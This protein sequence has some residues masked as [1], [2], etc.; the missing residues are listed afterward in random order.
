MDEPAIV[1]YGYQYIGQNSV[2][3]YRGVFIRAFR[4]NRA[5]FVTLDS[6]PRGQKFLAASV[7]WALQEGLL[8]NDCNEDDTQ[9]VVSSFRLTEKGKKEI[10]GQ[11]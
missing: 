3:E 11:L 4:N 7:A 1:D 6:N 2:E 8:Y 10:L 9:Q 5:D